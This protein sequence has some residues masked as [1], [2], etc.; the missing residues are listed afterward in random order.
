VAR[1]AFREDLFYRLNVI[2]IRLP[3]LRERS[4]DIRE[5]V[6]HFLSRFNQSNQRNVNLSASAFERLQTHHWPGN[7]RER[8]NLIERVVLLSDKRVLDAVGIERFLPSA[9][10][11]DRLRFLP[12]ASTVSY[13][14]HESATVNTIRSYL[15]T[16]SHTLQDLK[17][18][19]AQHA[20]N[21]SRSAQSLG[22]T[23]R[24]FNYRLERL[25]AKM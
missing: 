9:L 10:S 24:Q 15:P 6:I 20:G 19:L 3:S 14:L 21:R 11:R 18:A 2:P 16:L 17:E 8:A 12:G 13:A 1:E 22:M 25:S 7:I 5:L 23:L 4:P